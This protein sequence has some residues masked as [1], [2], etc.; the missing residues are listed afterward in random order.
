MPSI[1]RK[2]RPQAKA[3]PLPSDHK[4]SAV[5]AVRARPLAAGEEPVVHVFGSSTAELFDYI[6]GDQPRY[7]SFW[8][9]G[10]S[11][12][13]LHKA[14]SRDY[15]LTCLNGASA[16]D[17]IFLQ[18]GTADV[19]FNVGHRMAG[20]DFL[21]PVGFCTQAAKG[22][23]RMVTVLRAAGFERIYFVPP[24]G[25]VPLPETYFKERFDLPVVPPRYQVQLSKKV[26]EL[27]GEEV[28]VVDLFAP[29]VDESG[30]LRPEFCRAVPNH[31]ADYIKV[32]RQVWH[33]LQQISGIPPRRPTFLKRHYPHR[34]RSLRVAIRDNDVKP[35]DLS[36]TM[37]LKPVYKVDVERALERALSETCPP[38][39]RRV[40]KLRA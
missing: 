7:R 20:G 23:I 10:W 35:K 18:F 32:Q 17:I 38:E 8:L 12:R 29:F 40:G 21:D 31:H 13:G 6:F 27:L 34:P 37:G 4:A 15:I 19:Q 26:V 36:F 5:D 22:I 25:P 2:R 33:D 9:S 30:V 3:V 11:A 14:A 28:T 39:H 16:Q 1:F 24:S